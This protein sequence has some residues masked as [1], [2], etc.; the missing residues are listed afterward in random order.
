MGGRRRQAGSY[1]GGL[2]RVG[3]LSPW[4]ARPPI[5]RQGMRASRLSEGG[6]PLKGTAAFGTTAERMMMTDDAAARRAAKRVGLRITK[7]RYRRD[8][9]NNQGGFQLI[10]PHF[11]TV[12]EGLRYEMTADDV[13]RI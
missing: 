12:V 11:N 2:G 4:A 3:R 13:F 1:A 6:V 8:T 10:D 7:A 9:F 5:L